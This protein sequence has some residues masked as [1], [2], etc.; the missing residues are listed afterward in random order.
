[1]LHSGFSSLIALSSAARASASVG[2]RS[3]VTVRSGR[4]SGLCLCAGRGVR[5]ASLT[6]R[7]KA[8]SPQHRNGGKGIQVLLARNQF[9]AQRAGSKV[10]PKYLDAKKSIAL[11]LLTIPRIAWEV[12]HHLFRRP[13]IVS[14]DGIWVFPLHVQN[15][16]TNSVA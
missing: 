15:D 2:N 16:V 12:Q 3:T 1:M 5:G 11:M 8:A 14:I 13:D 10:V 7:H 9:L 6:C 4:T